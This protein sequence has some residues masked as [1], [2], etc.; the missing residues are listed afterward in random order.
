MNILR[1]EAFLGQYGSDS[2]RLSELY[3][4]D[5]M[6]RSALATLFPGFEYPDFAH[7]A[8]REIRQRYAA[9]PLRL[10]KGLPLETGGAEGIHLGQTVLQKL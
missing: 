9:A 4:D 5:E 10:T 7:L 8:M 3:D 1:A 2:Y 6:L